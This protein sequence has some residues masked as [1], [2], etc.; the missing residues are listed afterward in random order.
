MRIR[1]INH[2]NSLCVNLR[3]IVDHHRAY[4]RNH[5]DSFLILRKVKSNKISLPANG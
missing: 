2:N 4:L 5:S 1:S 3:T